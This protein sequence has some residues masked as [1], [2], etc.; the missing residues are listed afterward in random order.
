MSYETA[1]RCLDDFNTLLGDRRSY[2]L[3]ELPSVLDAF[4]Y[5]YIKIALSLPV[6]DVRLQNTIKNYKYLCHYIR[7]ITR[8][9][10]PELEVEYQHVQPE[11][12]ANERA[13]TITLLI[14]AISA[15]TLMIAYAHING[16]IRLKLPK[17]NLNR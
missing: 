16:I 6:P 10:Y 1:S 12:A 5:S 2:I 4:V 13:S 7:N 9:Y 11:T 15:T 3:G 14:A 17:I 8:K